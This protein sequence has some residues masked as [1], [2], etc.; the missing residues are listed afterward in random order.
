[1][2]HFSLATLVHFYLA[3]DISDSHL[4]T[5]GFCLFLAVAKQSSKGEAIVV[6]DDVFTSVDAQHHS[7]IVDLITEECE[8]FH[9]VIVTT[10]SRTWRERFRQGQI[11]AAKCS[12]IDLRRWKKNAGIQM[13]HGQLAVSE[14][15][16]KVAAVPFDRKGVASDAGILLEAVLDHLTL[17]YRCGLPRKAD[18]LY[19]LGEL[20]DG[21]AKLSKQLVISREITNAA[22]VAER[23]EVKVKPLLDELNKMTFIRNQVGSHFNPAGLEISESE[24]ELFGRRTGTL[25][26]VLVCKDC[27]HL[28]RRRKGTHF[29]CTC[30]KTQMAPLEI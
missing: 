17:Q 21:V 1:M 7:R 29:E 30:G 25:F 16:A 5:L 4:D 27:G 9:Q 19:T 3:I 23:Q 26:E 18:G 6:L 14:L 10:H 22:G 2:V 28:A 8:S 24:V 20:F 11:P 15:I 12:L 13:D